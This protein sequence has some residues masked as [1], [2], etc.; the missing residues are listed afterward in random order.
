M[1]PGLITTKKFL[2]PLIALVVA[3]FAWSAWTLFP[4]NLAENQ[5]TA[6]RS[7]KRSR[8]NT[9]FG[10]RNCLAVLPFASG[11][12]RQDQVFLSQGFSAEL[13]KL[14]SL[15]AV[16]VTAR[17]SSFYFSGPGGD[18]AVIAE[19][20]QCA[21]LMT[22]EFQAYDG[23]VAVT[24]RLAD[25]RRD[26][27]LWSHV[28]ESEMDQV[29]AIQEQIV[30]EALDALGIDRPDTATRS[31]RVDTRAWTH[32]LQGSHYLAQPVAENFSL[33]I[34]AFQSA[35]EIE[36]NYE[37]AWIGLAQAWLAYPKSGE[38]GP[39]RGEQNSAEKAEEALER[40]LAANP[41]SSLA[42]GLIS[43]I[44]HQ[45]D[46]DWPASLEAA[47]RALEL[48]PGDAGLMSQASLA[49]FTLGQFEEAQDLLA[50]AV[51]RDPLNLASRLRL[52]LVQEFAGNY[53]QSLTSYRQIIGLNSAFP[54]ARAYRAR[55]K[56]I[57]GKPESA[58]KESEQEVHPFWRSYSRI[59]AL[60]ALDR[61]EETMSLLDQLIEDS[62]DEAAFQVAEVLSFQGDVER[63]FEW[64]E[65]A[66][67][68]K[69]GGMAEIIGNRF[70]VNLHDDPRW[71][72]MLD[73]LGLPLDWAA[74]SH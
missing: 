69:D 27:E 31:M 3:A 72:V 26:R 23:Q 5:E 16:Q 2:T 45:V 21:N 35:L 66:Y 39:D 10:P 56:I 6:S 36:P 9:Y 55:V 57:Q 70:L 30:G 34:D 68:Q 46:W 52:G 14:F 60:S 15:T 62:G 51:E 49:L 25:A 24:V 32:F 29:F 8:Q 28:F 73:H 12:G 7:E 50:A 54:A 61:K 48:N 4:P 1:A 41:E 40:A 17:S 33:A 13:I 64:F 59:L 71:E 43:Y 58:L 65:R 38:A 74:E 63:A 67:D 19:R 18:P 53:E 42:Y 37:A 11:S 44:R 22:G 47:R 20:L